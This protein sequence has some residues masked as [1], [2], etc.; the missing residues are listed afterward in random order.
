M[1][2][3]FFYTTASGKIGIAENGEAIT[4]VFFGGTV[5]PKEFE[6]QGWDQ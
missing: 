3:A 2:R 1:K 4:N 6:E 5:A